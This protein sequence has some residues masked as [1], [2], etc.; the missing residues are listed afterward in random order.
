[1]AYNYGYPGFNPVFSPYQGQQIVPMQQPSQMAMQPVQPNAQTQQSPQ[2]LSSASRPVTNRE[3]AMGVPADFSGA[4]MV[5]PDLA[6]NR[7]Y[8][9]RWN[10]QTGSADF[11]EFSPVIPANN[12]P[13]QKMD[14]S[15]ASLQDLQDLQNVVANLQKEIEQMKKPTP[16]GRAVKKNDSTDE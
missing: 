9:K 2:G 13:Q 10:M 8:L 12:E 7:V 1:M 16:N 6:N 5:F 14:I 3:E 4:L 15:F 11:G